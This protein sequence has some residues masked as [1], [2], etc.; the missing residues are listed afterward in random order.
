MFRFRP[1]WIGLLVLTA[2]DGVFAATPPRWTKKQIEAFKKGSPAKRDWRAFSLHSSTRKKSTLKSTRKYVPKTQFKPRTNVTKPTIKPTAGYN[3]SRNT[4]QFKSALDAYNQGKRATQRR[5][6]HDG[7]S[8]STSSRTHS[9]ARPATTKPAVTTAPAS[10]PKTTP[11]IRTAP[12]FTSKPATQPQWMK[13]TQAQVAPATAPTWGS[14]KTTQGPAKPAFET[15]LGTSA[16]GPATSAAA[17]AGPTWVGA[18]ASKPQWVTGDVKSTTVTPAAFQSKTPGGAPTAVPQWTTQPDA[19][20]G[21][22]SKPKAS[23]PKRK[24]PAE[25]TQ[26]ATV[27]QIIAADPGLKSIYESCLK[28]EEQK[29]QFLKS[30]AGED[31]KS[32]PDPEALKQK[33]LEMREQAIVKMLAAP[34]APFKGITERD[35]QK[36]AYYESIADSLDGYQKPKGT[37]PSKVSIKLDLADDAPGKHEIKGPEVAENLKGGLPGN[38][39]AHMKA[40]DGNT[41]HM[42]TLEDVHGAKPIQQNYLLRPTAKDKPYRLTKYKPA[43][44]APKDGNQRD[45]GMIWCDAMGEWVG[46]DIYASEKKREADTAAAKK[47]S[48]AKRKEDWAAYH[49]KTADKTLDQ[50]LRE[51]SKGLAAAK[52]KVVLSDKVAVLRD[53]AEKSRTLSEGQLQALTNSL[54]QAI[55]RGASDA[56]LKWI[57]QKYMKIGQNEWQATAAN[58]EEGEAYAELGLGV[59]HNLGHAAA[60]A[61]GFAAAPLGIALD[62]GMAY[63]ESNGSLRKAGWN[64]AQNVLPVNAAAVAMD[65]KNRSFGSF[66]LALLQDVGNVFEIKGVV[67]GL[68]DMGKTAKRT[69]VL[70]TYSDDLGKDLARVEA[71]TDAFRYGR[72]KAAPKVDVLEQAIKSGDPKQ[73]K[74]A[75]LDVQ[76]D[77][78]AMHIMNDKLDGDVIGAFD[79]Q[80]KDMYDDTDKIMKAKIAKRY[81][82]DPDQIVVELPTNKKASLPGTPSTATPPKPA[83]MDRDVTYYYNPKKTAPGVL[84]DAKGN[85]L[86]REIPSNVSGPMYDEAFYDVVH[87]PGS[88]KKLRQAMPDDEVAKTLSHNSHKYDQAITDSKHAE[89]YGGTPKDLEI[90]FSHHDQHFTDPEQ[91]GLVYGHKGDHWYEQADDMLEKAEHLKKAGKYNDYIEEVAKAE[92]LLE[93]GLRQTS[94]QYNKQLMPRVNAIN[95]RLADAGK[96]LL[97]VPDRLQQAQGILMKVGTDGWS[98]SQAQMALHQLGYTNPRQVGHEMGKFMES[99]QRLDP[100]LAVTKRPVMP[101]FALPPK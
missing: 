39:A 4:L 62:V 2:A 21:V 34:F 44:G 73:I 88:S 90:A 81:G 95:K 3:P 32:K 79:K 75:V 6:R 35:Q 100:T 36:V 57:T 70:A 10:A 8:G 55:D 63:S 84:L 68:A 91:I 66:A 52:Q 60:F 50:E 37:D 82:C 67:D 43:N 83:G 33:L 41:I 54:Q 58:R 9:T 97:R 59:S 71:R 65:E 26:P 89:A 46:E 19:G 29:Q 14:P 28:E 61:G 15:G 98:P 16:V 38:P 17:A 99:F 64:L 93:E 13:P 69:S 27:D 40:A 94:K 12:K 25:P 22:A 45:D 101:S 56:E 7:K 24:K 48:A 53:H 85:P 78:H 5:N 42:V 20:A 76:A 87:G 11:Q 51:M 92:G 49:A 18:P 77:K 1:M 31:G 86:R 74:K 47:A 96:P 72:A 80:M 30:L 23:K